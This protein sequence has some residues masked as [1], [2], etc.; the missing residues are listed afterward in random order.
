MIK[1]THMGEEEPKRPSEAE[2]ALV[3]DILR[4][5]AKTLRAFNA[6][7]KDNPIC[8]KFSTELSGKFNSFFE[9]GDEL[10]LDVGQYSFSCKGNEVYRSEEAPGN[11][12]MLLFADG[13]RQIKFHRGISMEE[14]ID[15]IDILR[16]APKPGSNEDDDIVTL[17]WAKNIRHMS[18]TALEETIDEQFLVEEGS[19][20]KD[21][22]LFDIGPETDEDPKMKKNISGA[23]ADCV[24]APGIPASAA[25]AGGMTGTGLRALREELSG[26]DETSLLSSAAYLLFDLLARGQD[27][28]DFPDIIYNLGRILDMAMDRKDLPGAIAVLKGLRRVFSSPACAAASQKELLGGIISRAGSPGNLMTVFKTTS[29]TES[30][31]DYILLAGRQAVPGMIQ[32]LGELSDRKQRRLLCE[33]LS[34]LIRPECVRGGEA[35]RQF[36]E[37]LAEALQDKR[38]FLVRNIVM[39]L[40]MTKEPGAVRH[41]EKALVHPNAKV[42]REAVRALDG[43][44]SAETMS[45]LLLALTDEDLAIRIASLKALRRLKDQRVFEFLKEHVS[46]DELRKKPFAEKKELLETFA[47]VGSQQAFPFLS[48]LFRKKGF[49]ME[50]DDV[51]EMRAS[52]AYGLGILKSPEARTLLEEEANSGK[53][54]LR[55]ACARALKENFQT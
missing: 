14:I 28:A 46:R 33:L 17:L 22:L 3:K 1:K 29:D 48:G 47:V 42:R 37:P 51:T 15:F 8:Q 38:W 31:K 19:L 13:I 25:G 45:P 21:F 30:I 9:Y 41:L 55:E 5:L 10:A 50:K 36:I 34:D 49:F 23:E 18:Y 27:P 2:L 32:V 16:L 24:W 44:D 54:M 4:T 52:A 6:Y 35:G 12:S 26:F 11:F 20:R 43:I 39:V 7:P 40:G 53:D